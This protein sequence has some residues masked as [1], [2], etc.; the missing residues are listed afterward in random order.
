MYRPPPLDHDLLQ[1]DVLR[2]VPIVEEATVDHRPVNGPLED[3]QQEARSRLSH[4]M[5]VILSHSCD[6]TPRTP[7]GNPV[8]VSPLKEIAAHFQDQIRAHGGPERINSRAEPTFLNWFYFAP[9]EALGNRE[10]LVDFMRMQSVRFSKLQA[11]Q[12]L[13]E[14]TAE[15]REALKT[16]LHLHFCRPEEATLD[17]HSVQT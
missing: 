11:A 2:A 5:V 4:R 12:K 3:L 7:A 16:K 10:W 1:G 6:T 14:L 13:A 15:T 8:V 9:T 17:V